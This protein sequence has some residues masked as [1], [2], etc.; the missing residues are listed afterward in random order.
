MSTISLAMVRAD[1]ALALVAALCASG[2]WPALLQLAGRER[3]SQVNYVDY[4]AG[5][6]LVA[7][8]AFACLGGG[9]GGGDAT[10]AAF[11]V[12]GG[13]CVCAGNHCLQRAVA[14]G[15]PLTVTLPVQASLTVILGTTVN[16]VL[17]P[18]RSDPNWLFGGVALFGAAIVLSSKAQ[19]DY[20]RD[21][22]AQPLRLRCSGSEAHFFAQG[23]DEAPPTRSPMLFSEL[24]PSPTTG[25]PA[26]A[27]GTPDRAR[28]GLV[29]A[30]CGGVAFGGFSPCCNIAVNDEFGWSAANGPLGLWTANLLFAC[31]FAVC[32]PRPDRCAVARARSRRA[33]SFLRRSRR[34]SRMRQSSDPGPRS[35]RGVGHSHSS[36]G[37]SA[38]LATRSNF[39]ALRWPASRRPISSRRSRSSGC[40]GAA[41]SSQS[42]RARRDPSSGP[43]SPCTSPISPPSPRSSSASSDADLSR[44]R[45]V[46]PWAWRRAAFPQEL[47]HFSRTP[48]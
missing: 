16:Y 7:V 42:S 40:S 2:T 31:G 38:R 27:S 9:G 46:D 33:S 14:M 29:V 21:G 12:L 34:S 45:D 28:R 5:Y 37:S 4:S 44:A 19:F 47:A 36:R 32:L 11:A 30:L 10:L 39:T 22:G 13:A 48:R 25:T 26:K 24:D 6:V 41:T 18:A 23:A 15:C 20:D 17:Q 43:S 8:G 3:R 35:L 1:A